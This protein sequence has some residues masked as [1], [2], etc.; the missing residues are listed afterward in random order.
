MKKALMILI[1]GLAATLFATGSMAA[2]FAGVNIHGFLSQGYLSQTDNEF[3][4]D[5]R[6]ESFV[7]NEVGI[8]FGQELTEDLRIGIQLFGRDFGDVGSSDITI[9]WA[10]ADYHYQDWLGLRFGQIKTPHGLYNEIRDIDMLRNPIFLP[11]SVYQEVSHDLYIHDIYLAMQGISSRDLYLSIQGIGLYGFIDLNLLGGVSYQAMYGTQNVET[12]ED[13]SDE[14]IPKFMPGLQ[15]SGD[16]IVN[17][18]FEVKDKF[19]GNVT[20]DTPMDGLRLGISLDNIAMSAVTKIKDDYA[21]PGMDDP[22]IEAGDSVTIDYDKFENWVCSVEYT[23]NN[24]LLNAEYLKTNKEFNLDYD[25]ALFSFPAEVQSIV[26]LPPNAVIKTELSGWY[27]G[28]AYR[29]TDWLELGGYYSQTRNDKTE[30]SVPQLPS[31][32]YSSEFDDIALTVRFDI[33]E[34][35]AIKLEGHRFRSVY[36]EAEVV[37][38]TSM[39]MDIKFKD[40]EEEWSLIAAKMTVAF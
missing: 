30:K 40:V 5:T 19:A 6:D 31:P 28:A 23:W 35:W 20:W 39:G 21:P 18:D 33:N 9:D 3:T 38:T 13:I 32:D 27:V 29:F 15:I 10:F 14:L 24:L 25:L 4:S 34:F 2:D 22:I 16:S 26:P 11:D 8:N 7:F 36:A 17:G 37:P 1:T 12:N